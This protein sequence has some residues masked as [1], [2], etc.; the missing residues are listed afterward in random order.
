MFSTFAPERRPVPYSAQSPLNMPRYIPNSLFN[1]GPNTHMN[2]CI[3]SNGG[4]YDYRAFGQGFFSVADE[5]VNSIRENGPIAPMIDLCVYPIVFNYR[6]GLE[7]TLKHCII[8]AKRLLQDSGEF[9]LHHDLGKLWRDWLLLEARLSASSRMQE[10]DREY[11][12]A[13]IEDFS[14]TDPIGMV[15]R[16]P[17]DM[18]RTLQIDAFE[19]L[20]LEVL[21]E[22]MK[23]SEDILDLVA[24]ELDGLADEAEL[25][26]Y[27]VARVV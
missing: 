14:K 24:T 23:R 8:V 20:N 11:L 5:S 3:G 15:F 26:S 22:S 27:S 13:V 2:A 12:D 7:L 16:Y 4:P 9:K 25:S 19:L 17:E 18:A 1:E 21:Q 10:S 6:H